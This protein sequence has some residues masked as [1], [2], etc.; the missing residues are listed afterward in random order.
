MTENSYCSISLWIFGVISV[1]DLTINS[2]RVVSHYHFNLQF[3]NDIWVWALSHILYTH[4]PSCGQLFVTPW[5]VAHPGPLSM[6]FS[7]Q[8]YWSGLTFPSPR[9]LPDPEIKLASPASPALAGGFF[10]HWITWE[11][12]I[13]KFI[14]FGEMSVHIF[15]TLS[16]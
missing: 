12:L 5:T 11:A 13:W 10:Y 9:D 7:R 1:L 15:C 8:E 6:E 16:N 14:F 4:L 2:C 3:L